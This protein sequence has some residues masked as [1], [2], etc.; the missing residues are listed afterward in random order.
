MSGPVI[1]NFRGARALVVHPDDAN[2]DTLATTL[3]RLGLL[4][5]L[6]EPD[7]ETKSPGIEACDIVFFDADQGLGGVFGEAP[8]PDAA[9]VAMIGVEAPGRLA[10]VVRQRCCG[11]L[12]KPVRSSG[13][14][15][16]LFIGVNE[17]AHRRRDIQERE[18]LERRLAGRRL[19]TKAVL[20]MIAEE[21]IDDEEA[22]RR[23]RRESMRRRVSIEAL[24]CERLGEEEA[25]KPGIGILSA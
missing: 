25:G 8:P 13:V 10:R 2:R 18:A 15:T 19:V 16:A 1:Q 6:I 21:G 24:A 9:Y 5:A 12:M 3:R 22:Y 17:F 20:K 7:I 23:L 11:Y 4:V 14:F